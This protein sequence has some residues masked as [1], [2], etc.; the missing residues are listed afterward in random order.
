MKDARKAVERYLELWNE[1]DAAARRAGIDEVWA[2]DARY[3]DPLAVAEGRDAVDATIG[4]VQERF[5]GWVFRLVGEVDAHH[6]QARFTWELGPED[7]EAPVVGFDVAVF[8]GDGR[9]S[10]VHGF[11]DRVPG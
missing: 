5:P 6:G 4:A 11:L 8:D 1:T 10:R 2:E 3:V 7:G 9:I